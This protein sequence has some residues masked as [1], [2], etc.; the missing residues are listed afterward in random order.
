MSSAVFWKSPPWRHLNAVPQVNCSTRLVHWQQN[1][2]H[3]R[4]SVCTE[5]TAGTRWLIADVNGRSSYGHMAQLMPLPLTVSC[6]SK[7]QIGFTFLVPAHPGSP[8][9][10]SIEWVCVLFIKC[11]NN[12]H[13]QPLYR[14]T[15]VSWYLQL[16]TGGF[17]WC[18]VLL[19]AWPCWRQ[20]AHSD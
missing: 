12:R 3:H 7:I 10:R 18:E 4:L 19:P 1:S 13:L 17:Y 14:S 2:C 15:C 11:K 20:P 5:Q 16:R 9:Q 6:F 8:G